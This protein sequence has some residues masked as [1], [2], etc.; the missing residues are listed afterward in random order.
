MKRQTGRDSETQERV[1]KGDEWQQQI[2]AGRQVRREDERAR[3]SES[4]GQTGADRYLDRE[5]KEEEMQ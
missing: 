4:A 3:D 2:R 5:D 1:S